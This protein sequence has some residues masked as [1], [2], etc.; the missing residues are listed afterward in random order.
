MMFRRLAVG[1]LA[2]L[3]AAPLHAQ[4]TSSL[5]PTHADSL[6]EEGRWAEAEAAF[7]QQ[8]AI[9]PRDPIARAALG[10]FI[11]MKGAVRPGLVL[12]A[13]ARKFGL[14][15]RI[16]NDLVASWSAILQ[17][18]TEAALL[19]SDSTLEVRRAIDERS[20][21]QVALPRTDEEGRPRSETGALQV[22][23]Y[24]VVDRQ[25][26]LDSLNSPSRPIGIEVFEALAPSVDVRNDELTLHANPRSALT[27]TGRRFQVLRTPQEVRVLIGDRRVLPLAAALREL[28]PRWWQIDLPHG[29]LIVR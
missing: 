7:Y 13:E 9:A 5:R 1:A 21:F 16:T 14:D 3:G 18:R 2:L 23:W 8:S 19:W 29:I 17:W 15:R 26:G 20:L 11:A 6:L 24:D 28:K 27:A 10:R 4:S 25:I 22:I 12:I